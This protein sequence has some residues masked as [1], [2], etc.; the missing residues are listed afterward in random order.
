MDRLFQ[1]VEKLSDDQ[2][3]Q[4]QEFVAVETDDE[5]REIV[6]LMPLETRKALAD[7]IDAAVVAV[8]EK[9]AS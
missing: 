1:L 3:K 7:L 2:L 8:M 6:H 9:R 5:R 4:I